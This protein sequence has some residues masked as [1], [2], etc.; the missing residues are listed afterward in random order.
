[1][2]EIP[3]LISVVKAHCEL[4]EGN[5]FIHPSINVCRSSPCS[6][7]QEATDVTWR[8]R[9]QS[10]AFSDC[11]ISLR[12]KPLC[13]SLNCKIK[14]KARLHVISFVSGLEKFL[15]QLDVVSTATVILTGL[16]L[17]GVTWSRGLKPHL[18]F[19]IY[20]FNYFPRISSTRIIQPAWTCFK[21]NCS[22]C[23][24]FVNLESCVHCFLSCLR[25]KIGR[26]ANRMLNILCSCVKCVSC[27]NY[28]C[29]YTREQRGKVTQRRHTKE[30]LNK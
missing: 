2:A 24:V 11:H 20:L 28:L 27:L 29:N 9:R 14:E 1:M 12:K 3:Q 30:G 26:R 8:G 5:P 25:Q 15:K 23:V 13:V 22:L 17:L 21:L 6:R 4:E 16:K 18:V 10:V 7:G 19:F